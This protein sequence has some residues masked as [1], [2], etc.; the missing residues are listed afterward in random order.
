[1]F[2]DP[3]SL[4][5]YQYM[6]G[7]GNNNARSLTTYPDSTNLQRNRTLEDNLQSE[8]WT[9]IQTSM[10]AVKKKHNQNVDFYI[11]DGEGHCSFGLYYPLQ[12]AGFEEWAAPIVKENRVVGSKRPS[13]AA[14]L[15][16]AVLGGMLALAV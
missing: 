10:N 7:N 15:C 9:G 12:D 13:A 1:M 14:F 6:S 3:I 16:S 11:I 2:V 5:Y 4:M 8:W